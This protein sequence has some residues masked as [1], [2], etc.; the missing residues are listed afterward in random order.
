MFMRILF[1][2]K[3]SALSK[4]LDISRKFKNSFTLFVIK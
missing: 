2:E 3:S 4:I 1:E